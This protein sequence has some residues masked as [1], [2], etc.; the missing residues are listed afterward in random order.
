M[1][2]TRAVF[3]MC[4]PA[5][6]LCLVFLLAPVAA[7]AQA[8]QSE[9]AREAELDAAYQAGISA[10]TKGPAS[11]T[12]LDQAGLS[13]PADYMFVPKTEGMRILRA[14]GNTISGETFQGIVVGLKPTDGWIVVIRYIKEGYIKDDEA[15]NWNADELLQN[16]KTGTEE[17]NKDRV[18]RGFPEIEIIGWV[19]KPAYDPADHRL[20]WSLLSKQKGTADQ[21]TK[22]INYNT[23]ALGR[24]GYFSLNLLTNSDRIASDKAVA[25]TLLAALSYDAG[26]RYEDF[27]VTTDHIAEYGIAALVGGVVAKKLGLLAIIGVFLLKFA[28]IIGIAVAAFGAG[29]WKLFGGRKKPDAQPD[30]PA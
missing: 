21:D 24:D 18:A 9:A 17:S 10:G 12:L 14:L 16:L 6:A 7:R 15:K 30:N 27:N 11:V 8:P 28:K 13:I 26:K 25:R 29:I 2:M 23:Y 3:A 20:V 4:G 5:V 22:G 1:T 19:E